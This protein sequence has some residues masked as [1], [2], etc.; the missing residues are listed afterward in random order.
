MNRN[1]CNRIRMALVA[2][3]ALIVHSRTMEHAGAYSAVIGKSTRAARSRRDLSQDQ[4]AAR[5][6]AL[7][8][9][10]WL[11][12]TVGQVERGK[13]RLIVD[14][15]LALAAAV[16]T[17]VIDL[18]VPSPRETVTFPSGAP[19]G[20]VGEIRW[21]GDEPVF[22]DSTALQS[23]AIQLQ[24]EMGLRN[25]LIERGFVDVR[26]NPAPKGGSDQ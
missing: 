6:R 17:S 21:K 9:T 20:W 1:A 11:R 8:F 3:R 22:P 19:A 5:M 24:A 14:E 25:F 2:C 7:G 16:E 10:G 23:A 12:Q 18:L 15:V 13:R 26:F 4:V